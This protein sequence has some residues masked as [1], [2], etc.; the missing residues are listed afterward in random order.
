MKQGSLKNLA[1]LPHLRSQGLNWEEKLGAPR[2]SPDFT[3]EAGMGRREM[4]GLRMVGR[5]SPL[6][7]ASAELWTPGQY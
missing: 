1:T 2:P 7:W 4:S 6:S 3:D 5:M